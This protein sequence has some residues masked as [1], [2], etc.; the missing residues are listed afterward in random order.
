MITK[1][2]CF[3]GDR[4]QST[5]R[6]NSARLRNAHE[7][8]CFIAISGQIEFRSRLAIDSAA[9]TSESCTTAAL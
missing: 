1:G 2:S 5:Q 4:L 7:G 8:F 9:E 6:V 3:W